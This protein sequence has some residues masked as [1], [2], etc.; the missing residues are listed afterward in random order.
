MRKPLVYE[1]RVEITDA[2]PGVVGDLI[3]LPDHPD[4]YARLDSEMEKW[5]RDVPVTPR[6]F[7][8]GDLSGKYRIT[9]EEVPDDS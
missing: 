3:L 1:G 7:F 2:E 6:P 5:Y 9:I 4:E 8:F